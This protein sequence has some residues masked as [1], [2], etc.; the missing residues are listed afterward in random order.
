[1]KKRVASITASVLNPFILG[2]VIILIVSFNASATISEGIKWSLILLALSVLPVV[3]LSILLVRTG[4]L[5]GVFNSRRNQR[6]RIYAAI[7]SL[8]I[9]SI[10][11]LV[12]LKAPAPVLALSIIGF[13]SSV[14][15]AIINLWWKISL[16][17]A[18]V[19]A[20]VTILVILYGAIVL[21]SCLLVPMVIWART[22]GKQ[23]TIGQGAIG[24]VL[25]VGDSV[26]VFYLLGL[27]DYSRLLS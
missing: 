17:A 12:W 3:V 9:I 24:T 20:L 11:V 1:M 27:L 5:D 4:H 19:S 10:I 13:S 18:L 21:V 14:L 22:T 26:L 25:T 8:G 6:H 7:V 15:Y 23:H 2:L 16:H